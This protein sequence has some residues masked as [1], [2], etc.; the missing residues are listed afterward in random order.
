MATNLV[1]VLTN[2]EPNPREIWDLY[3]HIA[4]GNPHLLNGLFDA[5]VDPV[6]VADARVP[7]YMARIEST[8]G[9]QAILQEFGVNPSRIR[10]F[11]QLLDS[12]MATNKIHLNTGRSNKGLIPLGHEDFVVRDQ[13]PNLWGCYRTTGTSQK[14]SDINP[15]TAWHHYM[16]YND[17]GRISIHVMTLWK[18][19]LDSAGF[20]PKSTGIYIAV[21][22]KKE[23]KEIHGTK[24]PRWWHILGE[25]F[26]RTAEDLGC[27]CMIKPLG[28]FNPDQV[29][30]FYE[31]GDFK[32]RALLASLGAKRGVTDGTDLWDSLEKR[33]LAR[34]IKPGLVANGG[35]PI[36]NGYLERIR[37][38]G[39]LVEDLAGGTEPGIGGGIRP[40]EPDLWSRGVIFPPIYG[41]VPVVRY[42]FGFG[43][44]R[45][46]LGY[47][48]IGSLA[49]V[50]LSSE[51]MGLPPFEIGDRATVMYTEDRPQFPQVS[52]QG[53]LWDIGR[54]EGY[55]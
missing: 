8:P 16:T 39:A 41:C 26:T 55:I 19:M 13:V 10:T 38:Y 21:P 18:Y 23:E 52:F 31:Q 45:Q 43:N 6:E 34:G 4:D 37:D 54:G 9:G 27:K 36:P 48:G 12:G 1:K 2:P 42:G 25:L 11:S 24:I 30:D 29:L 44:R 3:R 22:T 33:S 14:T 35:T 46:P 7:S 28:P 5:D 50:N 32:N 20:D 49:F 53:R 17:Q 40:H 47:D 51:A 15:E